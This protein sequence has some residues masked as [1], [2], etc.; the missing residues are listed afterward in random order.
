MAVELLVIRR[1]QVRRWQELVAGVGRSMRML[2][3]VPGR[4]ATRSDQQVRR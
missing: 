1:P 2:R 3:A 4:R